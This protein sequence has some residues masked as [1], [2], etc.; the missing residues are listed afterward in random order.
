MCNCDFFIGHKV[1]EI[2]RAFLN[3]PQFYLLEIEERVLN[4]E[5]SE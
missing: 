5:R 3:G 1:F 2:V 4:M